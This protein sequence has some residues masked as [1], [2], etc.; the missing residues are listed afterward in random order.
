MTLIGSGLTLYQK[1]KVQARLEGQVERLTRLNEFYREQAVR[2]SNALEE[3]GKRTKADAEKISNLND[4]IT[5]LDEYVETLED[6]DSVCL[7]GPDVER[8][9][10]LW[11]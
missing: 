9:R 10:D 1:G 7:S 5:S 11:K 8:M 4:R 2:F 3:H 6:R